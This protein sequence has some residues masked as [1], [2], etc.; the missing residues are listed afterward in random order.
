[1][2]DPSVLPPPLPPSEVV[3]VPH[4]GELFLRRASGPPGAK[5][6][7]LLHGWQATA[8]VNFWPVFANLAERYSVVAFDLRGHGRSFYPEAPFTIEDATDDAAA[9]LR[10]L[11]VSSAIV[12]GYSLGTAVA[13]MLVERHSD[14]VDSAVL[15]AGVLAPNRRPQDKLF[16]RIGGWLATAQ[17]LSNGRFTA[18]RLVDKAA[19]ETPAVAELRGWL[20]RE[21]ERGHP[22]SL[23]AAGR[24][25]GRFDG[26]RI[27]AAHPDARVAVVITERDRL[28]KPP[29]QWELAGAWR[30]AVVTLDADHDAPIAQ[31]ERFAEATRRAITAVTEDVAELHATA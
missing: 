21:M 17:R 22:A 24:A 11:G 3:A 7:L 4:A 2:F 1:M 15:M 29:R 6:V 13:Q 25:L 14:L 10:A 31:P 8:D 19:R 12:V 16:S 20:T 18:H 5:T 28:V 30:A 23:R 26:R 9:L 27:A